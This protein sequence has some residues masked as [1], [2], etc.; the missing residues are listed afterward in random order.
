M[1]SKGANREIETL[2]KKF[3]STV[4]R[5]LTNNSLKSSEMLL[6]LRKEF[7]SPG[8]LSFLACSVSYGFSVETNMELPKPALPVLAG[9]WSGR[10]GGDWIW[11]KWT[12]RKKTFQ[13][14][15][16]PLLLS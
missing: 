15:A 2:A 7:T 12:E 14:Q 5:K 1:R 8:G 16:L 6:F 4:K 11:T 13:V 3:S 9:I 10:W